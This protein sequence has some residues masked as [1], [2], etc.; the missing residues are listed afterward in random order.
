LT[1]EQFTSF[2][3]KKATTCQ[4]DKFS[5]DFKSKWSKEKTELETKEGEKGE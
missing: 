3:R 1:G 4:F 2:F 5:P